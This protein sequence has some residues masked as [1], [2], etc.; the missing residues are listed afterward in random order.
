MSSV[1]AAAQAP[2]AGMDVEP[3]GKARAT[4]SRWMLAF[5]L[6][7]AGTL[8]PRAVFWK[9]VQWGY[10]RLRDYLWHDAELPRVR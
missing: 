3:D 8:R 9:C 2:L 5:P 7:S 10:P 1:S 4:R 6:R